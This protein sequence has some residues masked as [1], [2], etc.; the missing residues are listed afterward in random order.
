MTAPRYH[1]IDNLRTGMMFVVMFGHPLLPYVT[2]PRSF[3]D[4]SAHAAVDVIAVFLYAFA[5]Q[6]FF[7]TAGFAAA[8]IL[9]RK[10]IRGLWR[11]R[12]TRIFLPLLG[13]YLV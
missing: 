9:E 5:M 11:N 12:V 8:L 3:K 1:A 6:A 2:V 13:A 10:G 4:P 7:V